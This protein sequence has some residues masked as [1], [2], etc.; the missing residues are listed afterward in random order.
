M[1]RFFLMLICC[2]VFGLSAAAEESLPL[3]DV[4]VAYFQKSLAEGYVAVIETYGFSKETGLSA[5]FW[6]MYKET[7]QKVCSDPTNQEHAFRLWQTVVDDPVW[8][9]LKNQLAPA[10]VADV[11]RAE[12][13]AKQMIVQARKDILLALLQKQCVIFFPPG[14]LNKLLSLADDEEDTAALFEVNKDFAAQDKHLSMLIKACSIAQCYSTQTVVSDF[15]TE[16]SQSKEQEDILPKLFAML[17][18]V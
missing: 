6:D 1:K 12:S 2:Q 11:A 14:N 5:V 13:I 9:E 4:S 8:Q 18:A 16:E 7:A 3:T 10:A 15:L 17:Q